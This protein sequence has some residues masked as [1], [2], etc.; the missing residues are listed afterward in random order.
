MLSKSGGI[1]PGLAQL[2]SMGVLDGAYGHRDQISLCPI[3]KWC[4]CEGVVVDMLVFG[5]DK[6]QRKP[7]P[8]AKRLLDMRNSG[9]M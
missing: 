1:V 4:K 2:P 3:P 8:Y 7:A 6:V 5:M 9:T